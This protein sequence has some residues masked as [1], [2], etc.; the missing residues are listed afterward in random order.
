MATDVGN[1]QFVDE[2]TNE[3][4]Q[5]GVER[6]LE[7]RYFSDLRAGTLSVRRL[8]GFAIQHYIHNMGVLKMFALGAAQHAASDR[9]FMAYGEAMGEELT[10]PNMSKK[11][12]MY[13]GLTEADFD[14]AVPVY[15]ALTHTAV[16]L[17]GVFLVSMAEMRAN[18]LSNETMV[19][20]YA[21]EFDEYL[22]KEPYN[23]PEDAREFFIVHKGADVE[24]TE[25]AA[26]AI[27][28]LV[29]TDQDREK[30][31]AVCRNMAK[32]KLGKFDSIYEE[33]A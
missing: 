29:E 2:I 5:P 8:Q 31:R 30:V 12:G 32:L 18:A 24:H 23:V 9:T 25:R 1:R 19:Q 14:S 15:G 28:Q 33:Y 4:I 16:C 13:L 27:A 10:H 3:I 6:L 20:R 11:F 26:N 7:S 22:A 17:H 21:T